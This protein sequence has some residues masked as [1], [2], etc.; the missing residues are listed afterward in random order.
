MIKFNPITPKSID[1]QLLSVL[2]KTVYIETYGTEGVTLEFANFI[3]N[4]FSPER[5]ESNI[6]NDSC[7]L[8]VA[9]YNNNP[10]GVIQVDY[11]KQA[12]INN[13][14]APE[15]NKLYVLRNFFGKGVGQNLMN[16]AEKGITEKGYNS[17]WLWVL[18]SNS[19]ANQF[20]LKQ[21]YKSIG[22]ADFIMETN[23]YTNNVML[24]HL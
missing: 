13:F 15:I 17:S 23:T 6:L 8:W 21:G 16:L 22:T 7:D 2:F 20:Y 9:Q 14:S 1:S 12:P 5:I 3:Q 18:N 4:Q 10:I 24:K 11:N 19:R